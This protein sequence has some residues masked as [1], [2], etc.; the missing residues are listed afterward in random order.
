MWSVPFFLIITRYCIE[1]K[2][3]KSAVHFAKK[4]KKNP[5]KIK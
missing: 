5:I 3:Q 1:V 2:K 4:S